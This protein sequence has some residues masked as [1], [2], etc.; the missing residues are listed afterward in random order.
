M[1]I[2]SRQ[3]TAT[4]AVL[5]DADNAAP[6]I[7]EGLLAEVAKYGVAAVKR[8]YGDW[9][10][11]NLAG[12]KE[13]L[14][15]HS[16]QPIQQFRYTVGKNA[17]DSAMIIDAMDLLY[18][19][20]FD[21]FCIVS[22]DSDFTR[23][24]SRIREQGLTVYG[25]GERKTPKPFVTACDKFIFA[26][27]LRSDADTDTDTEADGAA[28][29]ARKRNSG[30]LRQDSRLVRLLQ[31]ASQA[32]SDEDGWATLGGMGNHIAKQAP[33]FDSRNYGYGKLSE[34]VAATG[35]F[36]VET[37]NGN[38]NK[39]LWVRLKR[40]SKSG[41]AEPRQGDERQAENRQPEN[42]QGES[43]QGENRQGENRQGENRQGEN[44]Q[45]ENRQGENRQGENRQG[46]NRQGENAQAESPQAEN[47]EN[48]DNRERRENRRNKRRGGDRQPF[49]QQQGSRPERAQQA[50]L[51]VQP[52]PV[53]EFAASAPAPVSETA[54]SFVVDP[55]DVLERAEQAYNGAESEDEQDDADA[56]ENGESN[57]GRRRKPPKPE[58]TLSEIPWPI[59]SSI[60][61]APSSTVVAA[62]V[63][64]AEVI[65]IV[66][67]APVVEAVEV[68]EVVEV[69]PVV[70][71][72]EVAEPVEPVVEVKA[73]AKAPARAKKTAAPAKK[74]AAPAKKADAPA[75]K[76][77]APAKKTAVAA[78]KAAA[79]AKKAAAPAKK[80]APAAKK[81][82][83]AAPA[84]RAPKKTAKAAE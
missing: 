70:E 20:R 77:E 64:A 53:P 36:E 39:T 76:A 50:A 83:A 44:R 82:A 56:G 47:R 74:A 62:V 10:K 32:V 75:K 79:P 51:P 27:V 16:I 26:D 42:R 57:G 59:D 61:V 54:P 29:P 8:I 14:L 17:T 30:E 71:A 33:E 38:N 41:E 7:V 84:K 58:V 66:E 63:E 11:P 1:T 15:S 12:W 6:A 80:A 28:A 43:R 23:L 35:L 2:S 3:G 46:E 81:A 65:E 4:L 69:A 52:A 72:A 22:S 55:M 21:G 5:I 40:R 68:V 49:P 13:R 60:F 37:R 19:G 31:S 9:T 48:R 73:K 24:A 18:T 67:V 34:L 25:F 78:K 45:G